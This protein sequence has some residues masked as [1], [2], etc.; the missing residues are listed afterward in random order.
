MFCL[1][2]LFC[3]VLRDVRWEGKAYGHVR[4]ERG[5]GRDRRSGPAQGWPGSKA[6]LQKWRENS[7][8]REEAF[9]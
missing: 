1:F 6:G 7:H 5:E 9:V 2:V 4:E 8:R 3:F